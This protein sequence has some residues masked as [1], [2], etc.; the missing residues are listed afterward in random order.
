MNAEKKEKIN[1]LRKVIREKG[2]LIVAFSG[3]VDSSVIAKVAYQELGEKSAAVTIH[4]DT[5]SKRELEMSK[6]VA[7]EIGIKQIIE[8]VNKKLYPYQIKDINFI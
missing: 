3:G 4:S 1:M 8:K 5:F 7:K 6:T 2:S